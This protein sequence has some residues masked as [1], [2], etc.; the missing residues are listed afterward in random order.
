MFDSSAGATE[1]RNRADHRHHDN[2][3][4]FQESFHNFDLHRFEFSQ[5]GRG[6]LADLYLLCFHAGPPRRFE[7]LFIGGGK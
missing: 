2:R 5:C 4:E 1:Q 3:K 6:M 7:L